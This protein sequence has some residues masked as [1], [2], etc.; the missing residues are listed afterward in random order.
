MAKN[1][2]P[3]FTRD[4]R[5]GLMRKSTSGEPEDFAL[6]SNDTPPPYFRVLVADDNEVD[7]LVTIWQLGKAWPIEPDLLVECAADGAEALEKIRS[8]HY[9][10]VVLDWNM[11]QCDGA[12]V[13]REIRENGLRVPVVV[14]SGEPRETITSHLETMTAAFV[15]KAE[16][17][18]YSFGNAIAVSMQLQERRGSVGFGPDRMHV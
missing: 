4:A 8:T 6:S 5:T 3:V 11:P 7:R 16:L 12:D 9:A 17:D 10:L 14:V 13:L 1:A 15:N 2:L 18:P